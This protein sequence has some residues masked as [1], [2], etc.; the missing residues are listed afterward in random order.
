MAVTEYVIQNYKP[1]LLLLHLV[2]LDGVQHTS[3]PRSAPAKEAIEKQDGFLARIIE[4]TRKSGIYDRTTFII[5]SDHGFAAVEKT[6]E[7][8][9]ALV[10][11]KLIE[12]DATGWAT[13]WKASAWT[14]G[15]SCAIVLKDPKDKETEA[16]VVRLFNRLA[17]GNRPPINRV[18]GPAEIKRIGAI[19]NAVLMLDAAPGFTFDDN[20]TGPAI[21]EAQNYRGTHGQLPSRAEMRSS[22][23][24]FGASARVGGRVPLARMIDIAP[25]AAAVL[26]LRFGEIEGRPINELLKPGTVPPAP[27]PRKKS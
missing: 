2:D 22:L 11:E 23:I 15:G 27:A 20:L 21:H 12:L 16:K 8:N 5:V 14:A 10:E 18:V 6:F 7:P 13:D 9:V 25:T 24:V 19:P 4:A 3:G 1:N 26:G 17:S